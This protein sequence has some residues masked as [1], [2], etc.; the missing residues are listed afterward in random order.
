[1]NDILKFLTL[2]IGIGSVAVAAS[3]ILPAPDGAI[4]AYTIL[5]SAIALVLFLCSGLSEGRI[6][7]ARD[8]MQAIETRR[9]LRLTIIAYVLGCS[10]VACSTVLIYRTIALL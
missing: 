10:M 1:M 3:I 7:S 6:N 4:F 5:L 8:V 2:L 9:P